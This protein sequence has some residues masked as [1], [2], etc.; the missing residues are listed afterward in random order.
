MAD[1]NAD[2]TNI[3]MGIRTVCF[4]TSATTFFENNSRVP[5]CDAIPNMNV[6]PTSVTNIEELK[7]AVICDAFMPPTVP[8]T[9]AAPR[10]KKPRLIF[11]MNPIA[12]TNTRTKSDMTGK[13]SCMIL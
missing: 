10:A 13:Y 7:P 4:P 1:M 3:K 6:T 11:L 9:N 12:T 8:S 2:N 5:F